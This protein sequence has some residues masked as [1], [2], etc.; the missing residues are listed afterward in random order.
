MKNFILCKHGNKFYYSDYIYSKNCL[1]ILDCCDI[2]IEFV[3]QINKDC[4]KK[5]IY[6]ITF[7]NSTTKESSEDFYTD[8]IEFDSVQEEFNYL[9]KFF[10]NLI[11]K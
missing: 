4:F 5:R 11:F 7:K 10:D 2:K 9:C 8:E 1:L 6:D 3:W